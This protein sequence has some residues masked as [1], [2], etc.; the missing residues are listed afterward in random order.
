MSTKV[1]KSYKQSKNVY[2]T[3][4][5]H[6]GFWSKLYNSVFWGGVDDNVIAEHCL[7]YIKDDFSDQ[8]L[9]VPVG[10]AVF[11]WKKYKTLQSSA[12]IT[13]LDYSQDML[14]V[15]HQRLSG[16]SINVTLLKG[17]VASL[18]FDTNSFDIV[19][20]MNGFHVFPD[21]DKAYSEVHR[22]L[23]PGGKFIACFYIA[24]KARRADWLVN[25]ILAPK[26]WFTGPFDT[27][28]SLR[29]RLQKDYDVDDFHVEGSIVY[30]CATKRQAEP[31]SDSSHSTAPPSS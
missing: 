7:D 20:S 16:E 6:N 12:T 22:V 29:D 17:D 21:K 28:E 3:V 8:L 2:D 9:D 4:L 5:T 15:A 27:E 25:W 18:P 13:C 23:K 19:L 24:G 26:G 30:F 14:D 1:E 11:T 10:T 31:E